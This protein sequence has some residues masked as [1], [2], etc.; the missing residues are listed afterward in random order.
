MTQRISPF[1]REIWLLIFGRLLLQLGTGFVLV[2]APIYFV[3]QL[4]FTATSVGLAVGAG[5]VAGVLGRILSGSLAD[6]PKFG[7][8]LVLILSAIASVLADVA[9]IA[10]SNFPLLL[11]G[12]LLMGFGV[13]LYWPAMEALVA[14][15]TTSETSRDAYALSRLADVIG[16]GMG[17]AFGGLL[18]ATTG[19]YTL[20]FIIDGVSFVVFGALL[21]IFVR[22]RLPKSP[23]K[24]DQTRAWKR[25]LSDS[26]LRV[27]VIVNTLFTVYLSQIDSTLPLYLTNIVK[28]DDGSGFSESMISWLFSWHIA[29]A[30]LTQLPVSRFTRVHSHAKTLAAA[31]GLFA[32]GFFCIWVAGSG[33]DRAII[34]SVV[35]LSILSLGMVTYAPS[36]SAF[37]I[38]IAPE[39]LRGT[40]LAIGSLCWAAGYSIG[41]SL[42]GL[43]LDAS[44]AIAHQYWLY[45]MLSSGVCWLILM[46]LRRQVHRRWQRSAEKKTL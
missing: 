5:Q 36:G 2:Y 44:P 28:L 30:A 38:D 8:R 18:I 23:V 15:L 41:P 17:I 40:Y 16:L 37:V 45:L 21:G 31:A 29:F 34:L 43:A 1:R 22:D 24:H 19:M 6:S 32:V 35:A 33:G 3:N 25:A 46:E 11:L 27:F 7:R 20:L 9:F 13:G 42:G 14:D 12:N 4:N 39:S 26:T 10:T